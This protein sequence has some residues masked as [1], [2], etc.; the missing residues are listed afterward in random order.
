MPETFA[1]KVRAVMR[2]C[3]SQPDPKLIVRGHAPLIVITPDVLDK[4]PDVMTVDIDSTGF[5]V[6]E[7]AAMLRA[8]SDTLLD[9]AGKEVKTT[10]KPGDV[11]WD[12]LE[13]SAEDLGEHDPDG[14]SK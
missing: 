11:D 9:G 4:N 14:A 12:D 1:I 10:T 2:N 13:A 5:E 7:L 6:I 3:N 8:L